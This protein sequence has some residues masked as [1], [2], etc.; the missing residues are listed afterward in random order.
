MNK[1]F[2]KIYL[3]LTNQK[4]QMI[5]LL[6]LSGGVLFWNLGGNSL[7]D[8]DE[9]LQAQISKEILNG[10]DWF[11]LHIRNKPFFHKPPLM[12]WLTSFSF[13]LFGINEFA[14]RFCSA[15]F[16]LGTIMLSY[17]FAKKLYQSRGVAFLT[18]LILLSSSQFIFERGARAGEEDIA[19]VFLV[20]L[21]SFFFWKARESKI[22]IYFW[23]V[24][25]GLL[26]LTKG[27][28]GLIYLPLVI[29][30]VL[31][32]KDYCSFNKRAVLLAC[33]I[34]LSWYSLE[35]FLTGQNF[36]KIHL[37][38][39]IYFF[40][41]EILRGE[42][43]LTLFLGKEVISR[44]SIDFL[45][46]A[47]MKGYFWYAIKFGFFPWSILLPLVLFSVVNRFKTNF[48]LAKQDIFLLLWISVP[49]L[50]LS[51]LK[52]KSFWWMT[53]I[54]PALSMITAKFLVDLFSRKKKF[55]FFLASLGLIFFGFLSPIQYV[56][57][58][59]THI[60]YLDLVCCAALVK[61]ADSWLLYS[62]VIF[63]SVIIAANIF[64]RKR[65]F[66]VKQL[67]P[68]VLL[69]YLLL[70]A[71]LNVFFGFLPAVFKTDIDLI[72]QKAEQTLASGT[73]VVYAD[74]LYR[75]QYGDIKAE[76]PTYTDKIVDCWSDYFYLN[77]LKSLKLEFVKPEKGINSDLA[78]FLKQPGERIFLT[79]KAYFQSIHSVFKNTEI[80]LSRGKYI[81]FKRI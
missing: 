63:L 73:L 57:A 26:L 27:P 10:G 33:L 52:L 71:F 43:T 55:M 5:F 48:S 45:S 16:G 81:L 67:V 47:T 41:P 18:S 20:T 19:V 72:A 44:I 39:A 8:L 60:P 17:L 12:F 7:R 79:S 80:V 69:S 75:M 6:A 37:A 28:L 49:L 42:N 65:D 24:S 38:E 62:I 74:D 77:N 25:F 56:P 61:K 3:F 66:Y 54:F 23:A 40:V 29:I 50:I 76:F 11:T 2:Q 21:S 51:L 14:A 34:P 78:E 59:F 36:L 46:G 30:F 1:I 32:F 13:L 22:N 4:V 70:I 53:P 31:F 58:R 15:C 35:F 68:T 9:A 64:F